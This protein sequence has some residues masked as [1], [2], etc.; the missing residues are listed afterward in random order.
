[1]GGRAL[2]LGGGGVTGVAWEMGL[3]AGLAEAGVTL[4]DADLV[5]GTSAGSVVGAQVAGGVDPAEMYAGQLAP[6]TGAQRTERI[7]PLL[8][9]RYALAMLAA[10]GDQQRYL[11]RVG[12]IARTARTVSEAERRTVIEARLPVRDWPAD[13]HLRLCAVDA[14]TGEFTTFDRDSGV[15]LVDAVGASCAV[16]GVWPPVTVNGR[17][18]I[19]GGMRSTANVDVAAGSERVVVLAPI[20]AGIGRNTSVAAQMGRLPAGTRVTAVSPDRA[21]AAAIGRN[22]LDPARRPGA[23]RAGYAQAEAVAGAVAGVWTG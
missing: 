1:M 7:S 23:A 12:R 10:R 14:R 15:P 22:V 4:S 16:P 11:R 13:R 9:A 18:W 5:V 6:A 3:I 2:V 20:P 8:L 19:D 17:Q 21:A